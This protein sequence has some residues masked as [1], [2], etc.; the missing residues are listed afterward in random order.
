MRG[1]EA[2]LKNPK[3]LILDA[4]SNRALPVDLAASLKKI[5]ARGSPITPNRDAFTFLGSCIY[6]SNLLRT[7]TPRP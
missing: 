3:I 6:C 1:D 5:L 2:R 4:V 7:D